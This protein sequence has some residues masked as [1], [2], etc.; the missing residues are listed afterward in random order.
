M[1][2][3]RIRKRLEGYRVGFRKT[4]AVA[5]RK[6]I[7]IPAIRAACPHFAA[8]LDRLESLGRSVKG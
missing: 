3:K 7:G 1:A 6:E 2:K 5:L 4:T 8:W